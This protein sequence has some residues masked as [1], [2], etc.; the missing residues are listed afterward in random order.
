MLTLTSQ[1]IRKVGRYG[2]DDDDQFMGAALKY[3]ATYDGREYLV[4]PD[5]GW[6]SNSRAERVAA[7]FYRAIG[8]RT[9]NCVRASVD[10]TDAIAVR[11]IPDAMPIGDGMGSISRDEAL[12]VVRGVLG[13]ALIGDGD[14]H[15][16]NFITDGTHAYSI[17]HGLAFS[18]YSGKVNYTGGE[19]LSEFISAGILTLA[20]MHAVADDLPESTGT[21]AKLAHEH[22]G[23]PSSV[24]IIGWRSMLHSEL[25]RISADPWDNDSDDA[26]P[27][28]CDCDE[29]MPPDPDCDDAYAWGDGGHERYSTDAGAWRTCSTRRNARAAQLRLDQ[30]RERIVHM[31]RVANRDHV[32][33]CSRCKEAEMAVLLPCKCRYCVRPAG[34]MAGKR[35]ITYRVFARKVSDIVR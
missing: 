1:T 22:A 14:K 8:I 34:R 15:C 5:V 33:I 32:E 4:K 6:P 21:L 13:A 16:Y 23:V 20:D 12:D 3:L 25:D 26:D 10:G 29:C 7:A 28:D 31:Q 35:C 17:D 9:A 24:D 2:D 19:H 11:L 18:G 27:D 30:S